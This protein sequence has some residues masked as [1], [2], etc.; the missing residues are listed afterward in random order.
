MVFRYYSQS[1]ITINEGIVLTYSEFFSE[2]I[3]T[4]HQLYKYLKILIKRV[5]LRF[6]LK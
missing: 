5:I 1:L 6:E 4:M 2:W 3:K